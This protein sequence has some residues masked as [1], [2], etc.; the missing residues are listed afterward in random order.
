MVVNVLIDVNVLVDFLTQRHS[1]VNITATNNLMLKVHEQKINAFVS[2][3]IIHITSY[4]LQAHHS[5]NIEEIKELWGDL[6][7]FVSLV[8]CTEAAVDDVILSDMQDFEDAMLAYTAYH[9]DLDYIVTHDKKFM[10]QSI[11]K[12]HIVP[13]STLLKLFQP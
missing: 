1:A 2:P 5:M 10:R 4:L 7:T 6:L 11:G 12:L 13:P 9:N 3:Q 8:E